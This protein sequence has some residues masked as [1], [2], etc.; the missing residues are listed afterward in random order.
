MPSP[1]DQLW[2][3]YPSSPILITVFSMSDTMNYSSFLPAFV[4]VEKL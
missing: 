3:L 1:N 4:E 2:S